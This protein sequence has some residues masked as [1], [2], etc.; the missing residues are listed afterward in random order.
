MNKKIIFFAMATIAFVACSESSDVAGGSI[1]DQNAVSE[2]QLVEW[3][4]F[5]VQTAGAAYTKLDGGGLNEFDNGARAE[6]TA[7]SA[8]LSMTIQ[9][10]GLEMITTLK[11]EGLGEVCDS[12]FA[13]F[14][15]SCKS[16]PN[17]EFY[18]ISKG[19]KDSAFDAAC[20]VRHVES[21]SVNMI[22]SRFGNSAAE[23]CAEMSKRAQTSMGRFVTL[24]STS[25]GDGEPA[26][27]SSSEAPVVCE[28]CGTA[29]H[30]DSETVEIDSSRTLNNYTLQYAESLEELSFDSH[31]LAYN[32]SVS[33]ECVSF[34]ERSMAVNTT[35]VVPNS[36]LTQID[37]DSVFMCFPMTAKLMENL[38][39]Q[40]TEGC[41]YFV[42][43]AS[44]G[45]QPTG[46][47]LSRVADGELE[48]TSVVPG[49]NCMISA[50]FFSVFFL[51]EDCKGELNSTE[52]QSS[53]KTFRSEIWKCEDGKYSPSKNALSYFEWFSEKLIEK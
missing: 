19:C 47:V 34:A 1:E 16:A 31:V 18:S 41:R 12:A 44:D 2:E 3:Y 51:V 27:S 48:F 21:E 33:R 49:G 15:S 20:R 13:G 24:S 5:G 32:G 39:Q 14:E 4:N 40:K 42:T 29:S 9:I 25:K 10:S 6:C 8:S 37:R 30:S 22:V 38:P 45:G 35:D 17:G 11:G 36:P 23:R 50:A 46:H 43:L 26:A 53:K 7:D 28:S 52:Y